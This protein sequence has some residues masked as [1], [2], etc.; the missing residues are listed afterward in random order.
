M[1][2]LAILLLLSPLLGRVNKWRVQAVTE[3]G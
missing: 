1:L 2:A 3:N